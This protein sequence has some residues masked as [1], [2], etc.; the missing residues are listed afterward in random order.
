MV[1]QA[2][3]II[4]IKFTPEIG[5]SLVIVGR[6]SEKSLQKIIANSV[7]SSSSFLGA[8]APLELAHVKNNNINDNKIRKKFQIAICS[9]LL[10]LSP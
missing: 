4:L 8:R 3:H 9:L 1:A 7:F 2:Q 10:Q 6:S 5:N